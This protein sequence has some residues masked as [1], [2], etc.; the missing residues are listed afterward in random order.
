MDAIVLKSTKDNWLKINPKLAEIR[1]ESS[2]VIPLTKITKFFFEKLTA[3]KKI[4][5]KFVK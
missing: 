5:Q 3:F 4:V 1:N 2:L